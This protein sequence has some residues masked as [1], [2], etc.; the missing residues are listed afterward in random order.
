MNQNQNN[1]Q[2]LWQLLTTLFQMIHPDFLNRLREA[3]DQAMDDDQIKPFMD[4]VFTSFKAAARFLHNHNIPVLQD[5][6]AH[7]KTILRGERK[8]FR[9]QMDKKWRFLDRLTDPDL[10]W[11]Y[12]IP[13]ALIYCLLIAAGMKT[14]ATAFPIAFP[15][16][17]SDTGWRM[18]VLIP[19]ISVIGSQLVKNVAFL[20]QKIV[21]R[22]LQITAVTACFLMMICL[23][24]A[25][26]QG[27]A[28][29]AA[30]PKLSLTP[31]SGLDWGALLYRTASGFA[32]LLAFLSEVSCGIA[33]AN[34]L[35]P[36]L[37]RLKLDKIER[38]LENSERR[39]E[40]WEDKV[41]ACQQEIQQYEDIEELLDSF[42]EFTRHDAMIF[43]RSA[44]DE[45]D[46]GLDGWF[47]NLSTNQKKRLSGQNGKNGNHPRA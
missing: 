47:M 20:K 18:A 5:R 24:L 36:R 6:L 27:M 22:G 3:A 40:D 44:R 43:F 15:G 32:L 31:Q 13:L 9:D 11:Y 45:I 21:V 7:Q 8:F 4:S 41:I 14:F 12:T 1:H 25:W 10:R 17:D 16:M 30:P 39:E 29:L 38:E 46:S 19:V 26:N 33:L 34:L 42:C 2:H 37:E 23:I 28:I 35:L